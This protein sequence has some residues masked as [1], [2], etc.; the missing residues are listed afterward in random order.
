LA[1]RV[2]DRNGRSFQERLNDKF[3]HTF[4]LPFFAPQF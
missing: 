3:R 1:V 4:L 2:P